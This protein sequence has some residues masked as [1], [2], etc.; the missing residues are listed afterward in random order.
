[1]NKWVAVACFM[2][3]SAPAL[4]QIP[5][6]DSAS[7]LQ[8]VKSFIQDIKGYVL[9]GQ[10]ALT[11]AQILAQTVQTYYSFVQ[12]PSLGAAIG[13]LNQTGLSNSLPINP[14]GLIGLTSGYSMSLG[15]LAGRLSALNTLTSTSYGQYHV[16]DCTDNSW[17]C[18]QQK[19][20][21]YGIAGTSGI[22]QAAYQD[23]R[24]HMPV[25]QSLRDRAASAT[26]PAEREN[27]MIALQS[28]QA[29]HDN[30]VGQIN[31]IQLQAKADEA[32]LGQQDQE[33][34]SRDIDATIAGIPQ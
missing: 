11:Q 29:W 24:D 14:N 23:I 17:A 31:A 2:G 18:D 21:A 19:K 26:T 12:D 33:R 7:N 20:R 4:A 22:A 15:G 25:V 6:I 32:S 30:M 10:Q 9:Q 16:Y 27:V 13:I 8:Q 1:M 5:V 28:E 3:V 34:F